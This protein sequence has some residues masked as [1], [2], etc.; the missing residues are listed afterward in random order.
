MN[1]VSQPNVGGRAGMRPPLK[2]KGESR[3][4]SIFND[5]NK[6][7]SR[8]NDNM[9]SI[10]DLEILSVTPKMPKRQTYQPDR[11]QESEQAIKLEISASK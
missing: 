8:M 10:D 7:V 3:E 2:K 11:I 4:P 9:G 6:S 5:D 1:Q